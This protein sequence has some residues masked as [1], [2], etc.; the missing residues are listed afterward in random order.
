MLWFLGLLLA[1]FVGG[2]IGATLTILLCFMASLAEK[3]VT[4]G[5]AYVALAMLATPFGA[6]LGAIIAVAI[7]LS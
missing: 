2:V 6:I 1:I 3:D 5:G 7:F 4:V